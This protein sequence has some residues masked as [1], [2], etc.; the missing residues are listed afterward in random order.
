MRQRA[1][2]LDGQLR[3]SSR[4]QG[5]TEIEARLPLRRVVAAAAA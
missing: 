3:I 5:G 4:L 1:T 2:A